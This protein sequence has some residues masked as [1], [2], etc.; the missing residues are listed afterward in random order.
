VPGSYLS[1]SEGPWATIT[2]KN[3]TLAS[4]T[5]ADF[6][7]HS[8]TAPAAPA[9]PAAFPSV[10]ADSSQVNVASSVASTASDHSWL[11]HS[12][13]ANSLSLFG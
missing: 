13:L 7:F 11:D 1:R 5:A 9:Q 6:T 2:L 10:S 8:G 3:V 12:V 4:L